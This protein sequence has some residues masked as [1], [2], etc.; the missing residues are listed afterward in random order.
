M[1]FLRDQL[2]AVALGDIV[3]EAAD[4]LIALSAP[5]SACAKAD[6][7]FKVALIHSAVIILHN[8]LTVCEKM[9]VDLAFIKIA[10]FILYCPLSHSLSPPYRT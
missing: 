9:P 8:A 5:E 6:T 3:S 7:V 2:V 10:V 4:I 1:L